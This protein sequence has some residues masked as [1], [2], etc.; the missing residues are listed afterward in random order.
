MYL[1]DGD[2]YNSLAVVGKNDSKPMWHISG[3]DGYNWR[4]VVLPIKQDLNEVKFTSLMGCTN[5]FL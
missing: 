4:Q 5:E 3:L 2:P 1:M